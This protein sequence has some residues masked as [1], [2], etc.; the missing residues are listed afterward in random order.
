MKKKRNFW[1]LNHEPPFLELFKKKKFE[2]KG[3]KSHLDYEIHYPIL[4]F[5][6]WLSRFTSKSI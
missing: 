5:R 1:E 4:F 2:K 3:L 6:K